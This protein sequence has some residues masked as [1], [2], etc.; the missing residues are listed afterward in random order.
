MEAASYRAIADAFDLP[1]G[2]LLFLSDAPAELDSAAAAGMRTGLVVR[3]GN[4]PVAK[5][6]PH[7]AYRDFS[8]LVM[9][10]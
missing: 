6:C 4:K 10:T 3:P 5:D 9:E 1:A 2:T 8:E 7:L